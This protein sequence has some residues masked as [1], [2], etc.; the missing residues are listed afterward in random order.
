MTEFNP[1]KYGFKKLQHIDVY[2]Y[3]TPDFMLSFSVNGD[4]LKVYDTCGAAISDGKIP[5]NNQS[6]ALMLKA[7][8]VKREKV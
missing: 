8:A 5:A 3:E 7:F 6:L 1:E 4:F 2:E